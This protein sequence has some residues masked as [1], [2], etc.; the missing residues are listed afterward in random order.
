MIKTVKKTK[1]N[2][3]KIVV[4]L[5]VIFLI[6]LGMAA[7]VYFLKVS[8]TVTDEGASKANIEIYQKA[9][10]NSDLT[11][12]D[13]IKGGINATN[14]NNPANRDKY[15]FSAGVSVEYKQ[16]NEEQAR[17]SCRTNVQRAIDNKKDRN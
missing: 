14:N 17:E 11:I 3:R 5:I 8:H 1:N 15:N 7:V 12:C 4:T 9:A 13:Q 16:M 2:K 10:R 6:V